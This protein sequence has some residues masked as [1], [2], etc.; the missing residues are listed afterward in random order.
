M[1][2]CTVTAN[3]PVLVLLP[4]CIFSV[5]LL[6]QMLLNL[7]PV[8]LNTVWLGRTNSWSAMPST[9]TFKYHHQH[10]FLRSVLIALLSSVV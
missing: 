3:Q 2:W 7:L 1:C 9:L 6:P 5:V 4:L 10:A 8:M